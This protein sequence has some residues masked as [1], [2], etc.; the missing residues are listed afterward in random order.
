MWAVKIGITNNK[1]F[2]FS[3]DPSDSLSIGGVIRTCFDSNYSIFTYRN[4][5]KMMSD[6]NV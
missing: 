6:F 1:P 3:E 4:P 5:I 2:S